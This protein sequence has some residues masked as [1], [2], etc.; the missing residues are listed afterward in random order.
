MLRTNQSSTSLKFGWMSRQTLLLPLW[1][2]A[3]V[4]VATLILVIGESFI[5]E[6]LSIEFDLFVS[7][8]TELNHGLL[9]DLVWWQALTHSFIDA[10]LYSCSELIFA[11][12]L[13]QLVKDALPMQGLRLALLVLVWVTSVTG[14]TP[15]FQQ[16]LSATPLLLTEPWQA[17]ILATLWY[18]SSVVAFAFYLLWP[19]ALEDNRAIDRVY[20]LSI[21]DRVSLFISQS[22]AMLLGSGI[23]LFIIHFEPAQAWLQQHQNRV[24]QTINPSLDFM[25]LSAAAWALS[26]VIEMLLLLIV[27]L[28]LRRR[29]I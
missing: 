29:Q 14:I 12:L 16:V 6:Q 13:V 18:N 4:S 10:L 21:V 24:A 27:L 15:F 17:K 25:E 5:T 26:F 2:V 20:Q 7:L 9:A 28:S 11:L 19:K 3:L 23:V 22:K 8:D 1:L